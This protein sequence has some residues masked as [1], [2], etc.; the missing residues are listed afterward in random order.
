MQ[1][2]SL[3]STFG[4]TLAVVACPCNQFGQQENLKGEEIYQSLKHVRPGNDYEPNFG[5]AEK[6]E[7]NGTNAH[8]LFKFLRTALPVRSDTGFAFEAD[9]PLG[10]QKDSKKIVWTPSNPS[11]IVWNFEKFIVD[12]TGVPFKRYSQKFETIR[13][14][15]EIRTL[16]E[17]ST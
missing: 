16:I 5:L 6:L 9:N 17:S 10:V 8:P 11:D 2:N 12:Q 3:Q 1:L 14:E 7:V 13:L 4:D 15:H